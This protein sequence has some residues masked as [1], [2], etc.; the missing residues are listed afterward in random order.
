MNFTHDIT[1]HTT[2][3]L[4]A[5]IVAVTSTITLFIT[6]Q[7]YQYE[8]GLHLC[9][10]FQPT[11]CFPTQPTHPHLYLHPP[12][13]YVSNT[14]SESSLSE[15]NLP[16]S[17]NRGSEGKVDSPGIY[18]DCQKLDISRQGQAILY[19]KYQEILVVIMTATKSTNPIP[20]TMSNESGIHARD[21][22]A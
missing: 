21:S 20:N 22:Q 19:S 16:I 13:H 10:F 1:T 17:T 11:L 4:V 7:V 12:P 9:H 14:V 3:T 6:Y 15:L 18:Q 5:M 2:L 8:I